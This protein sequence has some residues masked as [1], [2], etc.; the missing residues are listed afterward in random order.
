[1]IVDAVDVDDVAP[2]LEGKLLFATANGPTFEV[3]VAVFVVIDALPKEKPALLSFTDELD[4]GCDAKVELVDDPKV[5]KLTFAFASKP[6]L[7]ELAFVTLLA[8]VPILPLI[9]DVAALGIIEACRDV[10]VEAPNFSLFSDAFPA[11]PNTNPSVLVDVVGGLLVLLPNMNIGVDTFAFD[12]L[13]NASFEPVIFATLVNGITFAFVSIDVNPV[14]CSLFPATLLEFI[15][16]VCGDVKIIPP[17]VFPIDTFTLDEQ[18][19]ATC[20]TFVLELL[21]LGSFLAFTAVVV[22]LMEIPEG[23]GAAVVTVPKM[24]VVAGTASNGVLLLADTVSNMNVVL[25][26]E[27][28]V[29]DAI[30][31]DLLESKFCT[32]KLVELVVLE[33]E[34]TG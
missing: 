19:V 12:F 25:I 21:S 24:L 17:F 20:E 13:L 30:V 3:P 14:F 27:V 18:I 31:V 4:E 10:L 5:G 1:M 29:V 28:L 8:C 16:F 34:T 23:I 15:R 26:D 7:A 6:V 2:K 32:F 33:T 11:D 9:E 22:V